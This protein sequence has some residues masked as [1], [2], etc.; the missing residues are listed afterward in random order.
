MIIPIM[1]KK[2][3]VSHRL[4]N[5]GSEYNIAYTAIQIFKW[6]LLMRLYRNYVVCITFPRSTSHVSDP[7]YPLG[8]EGNCLRA[9]TESLGS[10]DQGGWSSVLE[11]AS[12]HGWGHLTQPK[13]SVQQKP[14][15][16]P[17]PHCHRSSVAVLFTVLPRH[18]PPRQPALSVLTHPRPL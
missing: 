18:P 11:E 16:E 1:G 17:A 6:N 2:L 4:M 14:I 3:H 15:L 12:T 5:S 13:G 8:W 10:L 7:L 9:P